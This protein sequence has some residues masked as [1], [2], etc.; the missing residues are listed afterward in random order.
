MPKPTI[1]F[2][3]LGAMGFGMAA[4]LV[5]EGYPVVGFDVFPASVQRFQSQGGIP[6]S[7]LRESAEGKDFYICMV[8]SAPQVQSVL[9]G[10]DGVVQCTLRPFRFTTRSK[11]DTE[12]HRPPK[13]RHPPPLFHSARFLRT[14]RS[15]G[16]AVP[17]PCGYPLH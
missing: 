5:R 17:R 1:G 15:C 4:N 2:V 11:A 7:S 3:G 12:M 10:E 16:A 14:V 13:E 9:F 8:A 6:A